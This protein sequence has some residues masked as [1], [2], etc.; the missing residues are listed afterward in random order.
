MSINFRMPNGFYI[1]RFKHK[2]WPKKSQEEILE[3]RSDS[4]YADSQDS[5]NNETVL[6]V[7]NGSK[8]IE[9]SRSNLANSCS[10]FKCLLDGQFREASQ[11]RVDIQLDED[12]FSYEIFEALVKFA[13]SRYFIR[14]DSRLSY[15]MDLI[16]LANLWCYDELVK[17]C[18]SYLISIVSIDSLVHIRTLS[19]ILNLSRLK[20][21][22]IEMQNLLDRFEEFTLP[23]PRCPVEGHSDHH[24]HWCRTKFPPDFSSPRLHDYGWLWH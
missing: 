15:Y 3:S 21:K 2:I 18:E 24:Y 23:Y 7:Y 4:G 22:C 20:R 6:M 10:Y 8:E 1:K 9:A 17:V 14:D 19:N 13:N 5:T 16:Q 11:S 12:D